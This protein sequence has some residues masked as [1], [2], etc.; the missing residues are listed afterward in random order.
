MPFANRVASIVF[1]AA[2]I[3]R[4]APNSPGVYGLSNSRE[5]LYI[6]QSDNIRE[7]LLQHLNEQATE[8]ASLKPSGFTFEICYGNDRATRQQRLTSELNPKVFQRGRIAPS[9]MRG[10][11]RR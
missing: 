1:N 4:V 9:S 10:S 6:G 8:L 5:W 11:S 7:S 2:T 3:H